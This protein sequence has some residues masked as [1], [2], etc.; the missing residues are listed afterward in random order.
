MRASGGVGEFIQKV[1]KNYP[2]FTCAFYFL[3]IRKKNDQKILS[4]T[5]VKLM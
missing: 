2:L 4:A 3:C 5:C 1:E